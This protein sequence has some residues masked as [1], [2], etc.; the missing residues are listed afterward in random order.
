[1]GNVESL[2][3]GQGLSGEV[4]FDVEAQK[5]LLLRIR[6]QKQEAWDRYDQLEAQKNEAEREYVE[7]DR[8]YVEAARE[9]VKA[10]R[11]YF[12]LKEDMLLAYH[13]AI[14]LGK[15]EHEAKRS[16]RQSGAEL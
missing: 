11:E 10:E 8:R 1:M 7:A 14:E 3:A 15:A 12:R 2:G 6:S 16:L 13:Q 5:A 9:Y 4:P